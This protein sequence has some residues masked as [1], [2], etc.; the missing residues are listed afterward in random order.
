MKA[1][2]ISSGTPVKRYSQTELDDD[3]HIKSFYLGAPPDIFQGFGTV[4]LSNILPLKNGKGLNPYLMLYVYD[5][6]TFNG[7]GETFKFTV[8][9]DDATAAKKLP[10]KFSLAWINAPYLGAIGGKLL[11]NDFDSMLVTPS[12]AAHMGNKKPNGDHENTVEQIYLIAQDKGDYIIY[13]TAK[14][15]INSPMNVSIAL[16][17]PSSSITVLGPNA[18]N[19][20]TPPP[21]NFV[22]SSPTSVPKS[23]PEVFKDVECNCSEYNFN[24]ETNLKF[25]QNHFV[26]NFN[27]EGKLRYVGFKLENFDDATFSYISH[28]AVIVVAPNG[29][30][31]Q[32]G[33]E[34]GWFSYDDNIYVRFWGRKLIYR[35]SNH[36]GKK[37]GTFII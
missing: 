18:T 24:F 21:S 5:S 35:I 37:P 2:L 29:L 9:I 25:S 13:I 36:R 27:A 22:T 32:V 17:Y 8:S 31:A 6:L 19:Y 7:N 33:G 20:P 11:I 26:S 28:M 12:G 10:I 16:T 23:A 34:E 30:R 14:V 3:E 4:T 1:L 15:L